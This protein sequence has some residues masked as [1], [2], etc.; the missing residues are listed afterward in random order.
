MKRLILLFLLWPLALGAQTPAC[1]ENVHVRVAALEA[2]ARAGEVPLPLVAQ[3]A[4]EI[5]RACGTD[6]A[7]L[8]QILTMF[9][10]AGLTLEPGDPERTRAHV[11]AFKTVNVIVRA[12]AAPFEPISLPGPDGGTI[13]FGAFDERNAYWD[14]MFAMSSDFLVA[15]AHAQV[16]TPGATERIGCGLYPAEEASALAAHGRDN[17]DGGELVVRVSFLART[18]DGEAGEVAGQAARYFAAH[19]A[20][21][22]N[23]PGYVGLTESDIRSGLQAHLRAHLGERAE[24][25]LFSAAEAARL[26]AF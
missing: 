24:S 4:T 2:K 16:Y 10:N 17:V 11:N 20:A 7:L 25:D 26:L 19:H 5:V 18:C 14:L 13:P 9:T 1:P 3:T 6:R 22:A 8:A 21:R 12:G 23:D 15:G